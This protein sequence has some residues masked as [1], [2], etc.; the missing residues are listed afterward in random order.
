MSADRPYFVTTP[1]YY[2]NDVPHLGHAYTTV[3]CDVLA[4]FMRLDG[5]RVKFLT[6][7]DEHG[8]KVE[9]SAQAL[10]LTPQEF[11]DRISPAWRDMTQLLNI[12]NDDFIRTTEERH[13]RGVQDRGRGRMA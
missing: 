7:S 1:I 2:V 6:G 9:R 4:R 10:G 11:C 13:I 8:E 3:V 5:R 12:S